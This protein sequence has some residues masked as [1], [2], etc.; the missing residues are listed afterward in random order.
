MRKVP[1]SRSRG[2]TKAIAS[3][4][5]CWRSLPTMRS[6]VCNSTRPSLHDRPRCLWPSARLCC[7]SCIM[8]MQAPNFRDRDHFPRCGWLDGAG[9]RISLA[10]AGRLAD[11]SDADA[12]KSR[13]I[14]S[15]ARR[16]P[17]VAGRSAERLASLATH[18]R[19]TP[20]RRDRW[21]E[22]E[23]DGWSVCRRRPGV[24]RRGRGG[25]ASSGSATARRSRRAGQR[26]WVAERTTLS[27]VRSRTRKRDAVNDAGETSACQGFQ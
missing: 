4:S 22:G 11:R 10:I 14:A 19:A 20:R 27:R 12:A 9:F 26:P 7:P 25:P 23:D 2:R 16:S 15:C 1:I 24:V 5:G 21:D 18:A 3:G 17:C 8:M 13:G 6:P